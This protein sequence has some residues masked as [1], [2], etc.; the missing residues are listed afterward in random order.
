MLNRV[1]KILAVFVVMA[2]L[3]ALLVG[4]ALPALLALRDDG[5]DG[6]VLVAEAV[7][8]VPLEAVDNGAL[9]YGERKTGQVRLVRR[10]GE[11]A[12]DP[13]AEVS[14]VADDRH[15]GLLGLVRL[16]D[17]RLFAAWT[18]PLDSRLVVG[19]IGG[20]LEKARLLWLGPVSVAQGN[21][22]HLEVSPRGKI[23]IGVG[24]IGATELI[25]DP[26]APNGKMLA[27]DPDRGMDQ[28]PEIL[29]SGWRNPFAFAYD[30]FDRLWVA[31][32]AGPGTP[33]RI[34]LGDKEDGAVVELNEN[35]APSAMIVLPDGDLG[36]CGFLDGEMRRVDID[37]A[38]RPGEDPTPTLT[39]D[40]I[41]EPCTVGAAV[42]PNGTI[43][44]ST[45]TEIRAEG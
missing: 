25:D 3:V 33:E 18:R 26:E 43:I 13:L 17:G 11:L 32:N 8:P 28:T 14:V 31:D 4:A 12:P 10:N 45:P 7:F 23:V 22:G 40:V 36:V 15:Q 24:D 19:E 35:L 16:A 42:L 9:L 44:F 2:A 1:A 21:G 30:A 27:L 39:D 20:D 29:S 5:L 38:D 41:L 34:G 37:Q 6:S